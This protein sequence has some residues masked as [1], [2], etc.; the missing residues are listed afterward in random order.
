MHH[1]KVID[2]CFLK[3]CTLINLQDTLGS[4]KPENRVMKQAS[5]AG[6]SISTLFYMSCGLLGYAA[7]GDTAPGNILAGFGFFEPFWLIDLANIFVV[8]HLTGAYQVNNEC[9]L[10]V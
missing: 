7:F 1:R 2:F 10:F 6:I 8:I 4:S 3:F 9:D 5:L